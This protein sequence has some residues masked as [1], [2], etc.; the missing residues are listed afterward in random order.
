[1]KYTSELIEQILTSPSAR[2]GL[3]YITPI[4]QKA[5]TALWIMQSIG[6]Q[7]DIIIK[8]IDEY[9]KQI[10]PQTAT[11]SI[12]YFE[13]EYGIPV[14]EKLTIEER[15]KAV[16]L[17]IL[18]R[19]PMNPAKLSDMLS[20]SVNVKIN[21]KENTGKNT[22]FAECGEF[23]DSGQIKKMKNILDKYKPAHLI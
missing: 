4:Y 8:W 11:W 22:F 19:A 2:R 1:M 13:E 12:P 5:C 9:K 10:L 15:R 6:L 14:N 17:A 3:D 23:I 7:T 16:I 20:M 18:A 21:I